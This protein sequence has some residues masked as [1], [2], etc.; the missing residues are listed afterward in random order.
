[1]VLGEHSENLYQNLPDGIFSE[2]LII[3]IF[4]L[5]NKEIGLVQMEVCSMN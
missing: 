3:I 4:V 2:N 1:M 5:S